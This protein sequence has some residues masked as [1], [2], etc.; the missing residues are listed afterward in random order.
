[1]HQIPTELQNEAGA[2]AEGI[3]LHVMPSLSKSGA[4]LGIAMVLK[5]ENHSTFKVPP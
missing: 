2:A 1:M 4:I 5:Q 3:C